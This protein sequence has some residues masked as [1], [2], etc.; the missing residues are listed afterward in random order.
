MMSFPND[1]YFVVRFHSQASDTS[2]EQQYTTTG[3]GHY[4]MSIH[5]Y[6]AA[7]KLP[8]CKVPDRQ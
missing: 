1:G 5:V 8:M 6:F 3:I 7:L 2:K 4:L